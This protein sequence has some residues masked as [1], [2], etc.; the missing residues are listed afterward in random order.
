M[1]QAN[2]LRI[3]NWV[4]FTGGKEPRYCKVV[5]IAARKLVVKD[6]GLDLV[7]N[8][9]SASVLPQAIPL[10]PE[11][12]EKAGFEKTKGKEGIYRNGHLQVYMGDGAMAYIFHSDKVGYCFLRDL[13]YLHELQNLYAVIFSE[14][15]TINL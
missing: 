6:L 14:E 13:K 12:L 11:I 8:I 9:D 5:E 10:T 7:M 4:A 2:E 15:L 1:I 3:G